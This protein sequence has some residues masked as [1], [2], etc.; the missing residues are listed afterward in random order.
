MGFSIA[1]E[2]TQAKFS[3]ISD[4]ANEIRVVN[5]D[6]SSYSQITSAVTLADAVVASADFSTSTSAG[7]RLLTLAEESRHN[8]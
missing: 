4:N 6:P 8:C 1:D 2:A 7:N 5:N 3:Y